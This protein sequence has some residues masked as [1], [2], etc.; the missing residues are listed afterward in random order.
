MKENV[1]HVNPNKNDALKDWLVK[2]LKIEKFP[3][4]ISRKE[5]SINRK[6]FLGIFDRLNID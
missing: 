2:K 4:L 5:L 1:M 6:K 3:V